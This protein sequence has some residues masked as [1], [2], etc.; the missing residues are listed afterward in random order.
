MGY[1]RSI[2]SMLEAKDN[3]LGK[4]LLIIE[5]QEFGVVEK[6]I[7]FKLRDYDLNTEIKIGESNRLFH[8]WITYYL[9]YSDIRRYVYPKYLEKLKINTCV[10]CNSEFISTSHL[11]KLDDY[12]NII[13]DER[14]EA[15]IDN[16]GRFQLDHFWPKSKH[17]F[18]S[19]TFFNLQPSCNF[20]NLWKSDADIPFNLFT[21]KKNLP[22]PFKFSVAEE[23]IIDYVSSHQKEFLKLHFKS[24][25]EN[26]EKFHIEEVYESF[27]DEVEEL[28]WK[29]V[30]NGISYLDMLKSSLPDALMVDQDLL[31][32]FFYGY[33]KDP[34]DILKRPLTKMK[35]DIA[36]QLEKL[37]SKI[38]V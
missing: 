16:K 33:Y 30:S 15:V 23:N 10:Y 18:L 37:A 22:S 24:S 27:K 4:S 38:R 19:I 11:I 13:K 7:F 25:V 34:K 12:G 3:F 29:K 17:P 21:N 35:Q 32:R 28:F 36:I 8:E 31:F 1:V 14:N 26:Y 20:C 2:Q 6:K 5:P 9:H